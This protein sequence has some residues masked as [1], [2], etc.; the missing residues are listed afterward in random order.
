MANFEIYKSIEGRQKTYLIFKK[1][2]LDI[3]KAKKYFRCSFLHLK[4]VEGWIH[5]ELLY[6]KRPHKKGVVGVWVAYYVR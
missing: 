4:I 3:P 6:L 2:S 5:N 1:G